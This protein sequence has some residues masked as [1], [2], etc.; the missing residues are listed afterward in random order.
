M[1]VTANRRKTDQ[2]Q[3]STSPEGVEEYVRRAM[4][5]PGNGTSKVSLATLLVEFQ[6]NWSGDPEDRQLPL[7]FPVGMLNWFTRLC[8]EASV[9]SQEICVYSTFL[10]DNRLYQV[11]VNHHRSG[12]IR[13]R[14]SDGSE[15]IM[16]TDSE[17]TVSGPY[18][19]EQR[20]YWRKYFTPE[21]TK[22]WVCERTLSAFSTPLERYVPVTLPHY[23]R[24]MASIFKEAY[25][26]QYMLADWKPTDQEFWEIEGFA[27]AQEMRP[28]KLVSPE[29][30]TVMHSLRSQI[31]W[32]YQQGVAASM[33]LSERQE[34][35]RKLEENIRYE[36]CVILGID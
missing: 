17:I 27:R 1:A 35:L 8:R 20:E 10:S 29:L 11:Q 30:V 18:A 15:V 7:R 3:V 9:Q 12:E 36:V 13:G 4:S 21:K 31:T 23:M 34:T 5:D 24:T 25:M 19:A 26:T 28:Q 2:I 22:R 16:I 33:S 14:V 32:L 6:H